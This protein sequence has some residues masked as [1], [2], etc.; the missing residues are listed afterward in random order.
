MTDSTRLPRKKLLSSTILIVRNM[1]I[2][3]KNC[4]LKSRLKLPGRRKRTIRRVSSTSI[5]EEINLLAAWRPLE[6]TIL[7]IF[8][9]DSFNS[10]KLSRL[11]L[12]WLLQAVY[13]NSDLSSPC[14]LLALELWCQVLRWIQ[15]LTQWW[16]SRL[17]LQWLTLLFLL[18]LLP[19]PIQWWAA[20]EEWE[21]EECPKEDTWIQ[22]P[23]CTAKEATECGDSIAL[24][25]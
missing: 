5:T 11:I 10:L 6:G 8:S 21:W 1:L 23:S 12:W 24:F 4:Q 19:Q 22:C 17:D 18:F 9:L 16:C 14:Q 13:L 25:Y 20:W 15:C 7:L 2:T 3:S